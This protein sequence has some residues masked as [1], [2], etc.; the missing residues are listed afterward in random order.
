MKKT[1]KRK[2]LMYL[3]FKD[4]FDWKDINKQEIYQTKFSTK[5][6]NYLNK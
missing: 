4:Y 6:F 5:V 3:V 1:F 2:I